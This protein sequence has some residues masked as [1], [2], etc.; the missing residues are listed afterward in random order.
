MKCPSAVVSHAS[1]GSDMIDIPI[2]IVNPT[3][4]RESKTYMLSL[5][6][7]KMASLKVSMYWNSWGKVLLALVY[8]LMWNTSLASIRFVLLKITISELN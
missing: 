6:L 3:N 8:S 2:K 4:E 5:Q 1:K 7:E